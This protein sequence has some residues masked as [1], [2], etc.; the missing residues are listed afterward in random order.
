VTVDL[1]ADYH[2]DKILISS[3]PSYFTVLDNACISTFDSSG[4]PQWVGV[5]RASV[6]QDHY[7]VPLPANSVPGAV[8]SIKIHTRAA[9]VWLREVVA[10]SGDANVAIGAS[11]T[12]SPGHA[13]GPASMCVD[14]SICS[15]CKTNG[16]GFLSIDFGADYQLHKVLIYNDVVGPAALD[17]ACI[18]AYDSSGL[19]VWSGFANASLVQD[20][21]PVT[22]TASSVAGTVRSVKI[23]SVAGSLWMMEVIVMSGGVNIATGA[24]VVA[25][26]ANGGGPAPL[27]IDASVCTFCRT[28]G[29][30]YVSVTF[31]ADYHVDEI[32]LYNHAGAPAG[33]DGAC[34]NLFDSAGSSRWSAAANASLVQ[35]FSPT[36][37]D[38]SAAI[39]G[40]VRY[41]KVAVSAASTIYL[42]EVVVMSGG[43]NVAASSSASAVMTPYS[44]AGPPAR[45]IDDSLCT[46]C[47][48]ASGPADVVIDL[49]GDYHVESVVLYNDLTYFANIN[50][51]AIEVLNAGGNT[52]W[53]GAL[54][55]TLVQTFAPGL[56]PT[57]PPTATQSIGASRS[58][59]I[60]PSGSP[61][62]TATGT[63]SHTATPSL[64]HS[65]T[66]S[67]AVP[68]TRSVSGAHS[69]SAVPTPSSAGT[70]SRTERGS[71]SVEVT[72]SPA[73]SA[74][75]QGSATVTEATPPTAASRPPHS[76]QLHAVASAS[77][78]YTATVTVGVL[79]GTNA[80]AVSAIAF[81]D[82]AAVGVYVAV[83][84]DDRCVNV[85]ENRSVTCSKAVVT[86]WSFTL[87]V[88]AP[89]YASSAIAVRV[90]IT[91]RDADAVSLTAMVS[92][93]IAAPPQAVDP[94]APLSA[95]RGLRC[96]FS[97]DGGCAAPKT[98]VLLIVCVVFVALMAARVARLRCGEQ[99]C[100]NSVVTADV[101][102]ARALVSLHV[103][104]GA[105]VPCHRRCGPIHAAALFAHVLVMAAVASSLIAFYRA[106]AAD[107][108]VLAVFGFFASLLATATTAAVDT[109]FRWVALTAHTPPYRSEQYKPQDLTEFGIRRQTTVGVDAN[110]IRSLPAV[111]FDASP[112]DS[113]AADEA[114]W[115]GATVTT[116]VRWGTRL[117]SGALA[118]CAATAFA[119]T[120]ANTLTWCGEDYRAF[121]RALLAAVLLDAAVVQTAAVCVAWLGRWT[122]SEEQDGRAVHNLHPVGDQTMPD[123]QELSP[124]D[125]AEGFL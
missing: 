49:G 75:E 119:T 123:A 107:A 85:T 92:G 19:S 118:A 41:V 47:R 101:A 88:D 87:A 8:R 98:P 5:G 53:T 114:A 61:P 110:T 56:T 94:A 55:S 66:V 83:S 6:V 86:E 34:V 21:Y 108:T 32:R 72:A 77:G 10:M 62:L 24:S 74:S 76:K 89:S 78:R 100:P 17:G 93:N 120:F 52:L 30:G 80:T 45:C 84:A 70:P 59:S 102:A 91:A 97:I 58:A 26:P 38:F 54:D 65:A 106:L 33:L 79:N 109:A 67:L 36:L 20:Y 9:S 18:N 111:S 116:D 29:V 3:H 73:V 1:G 63:H 104:A 31:G 103:W 43:V 23:H 48:S 96:V 60:A 35:P 51:G 14:A 57:L 117:G 69:A 113:K 82:A 2:V 99:P 124:D 40:R 81:A 50:G 13:Q 16:L 4:V 90:H 121:E 44:S 125:D 95:E 64:T 39:A 68:V 27:C 105:A 12:T 37:H 11:A 112:H 15:W 122:V 7:P 28:N 25:Q 22:S 46:V 71:S 42:R 115:Y